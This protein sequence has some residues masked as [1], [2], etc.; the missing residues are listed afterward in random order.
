MRSGGPLSEDIQFFLEMTTKS[1][2]GSN[3]IHTEEVRATT[4]HVKM[5]MEATTGIL[6]IRGRFIRLLL[7]ETLSLERSPVRE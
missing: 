4:I 1:L 7:E 5:I 3:M 6:R 2:P